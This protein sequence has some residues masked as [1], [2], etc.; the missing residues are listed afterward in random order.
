MPGAAP[1]FFI[2]VL[3]TATIASWARKQRLAS[4]AALHYAAHD[5]P[6][7]GGDGVDQNVR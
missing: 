2:R 7:S 3:N 5:I 1:L 6:T 4:C